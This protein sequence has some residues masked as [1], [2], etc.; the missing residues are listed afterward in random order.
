MPTPV[1]GK[2]SMMMV[3]DACFAGL[4]PHTSNK[5]TRPMMWAW[6]GNDGSGE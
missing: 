5:T 1:A 4:K 6:E 3:A 2:K